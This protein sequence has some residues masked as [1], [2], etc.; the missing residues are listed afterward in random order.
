MNANFSFNRQAVV[1][2]SLLLAFAVGSTFADELK[3][4]TITHDKDVATRTNMPPRTEQPSSLGVTFDADVAKRTNMQRQPGDV[5]PV[6]ITQDAA[7]MERTNMND[8]AR[9]KPAQ[10]SV[11]ATTK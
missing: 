7:V 10:P 1:A 9:T 2:G 8:S 4:V 6:T 11:Q 5:A 3:N